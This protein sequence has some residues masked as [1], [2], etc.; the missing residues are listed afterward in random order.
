MLQA[1][2]DRAD[3]N[4]LRAENERISCE[5][6]ALK[7]TLNHVICPGCGGPPFGQDER[8]CNLER[9]RLENAQLKLEVSSFN[10]RTIYIH[11]INKQTIDVIIYRVN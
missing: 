11:L 10:V 5:N 3:N 4:A 8:K 7:E 2:I 1:Q 6:Y 9:L